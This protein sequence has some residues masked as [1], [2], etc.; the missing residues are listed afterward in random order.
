MRA[1]LLFL[2]FIALLRVGER[3]HSMNNWRAMKRVPGAGLVSEVVFPW[4]VAVHTLLFVFGPLELL[5]PWADLGGW[6]T[7]FSLSVVG[8][9]LGLR[10]WVLVTLGRRWNVRVM[11][12]EGL[13]IVTHG[14]YRWIR[15]PNYLVVILELAFIPLIAHL[16]LTSL[17]LTLANV[18]VLWV[19]IKTE[20]RFL[21]THQRWVREMA[22]KPRFLPWRW[23]SKS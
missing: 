8:L 22:N 15:H 11:D 2:G 17:V 18:P 4:M 16:Y 13:N 5:A 20:E 21:A 9:A 12:G 3:L 6:L 1:Y 23:A 7:P 10:L 14:P 19:R